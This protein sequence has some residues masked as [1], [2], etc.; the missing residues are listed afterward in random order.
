MIPDTHNTAREHIAGIGVD[1][2][3]ID[4]IRR[5]LQTYGRSFVNRVF[6]EPEQRYCGD[7][8][9]PAQHYAARFA[10]KEAAMKV[11]G[12]GWGNGIGW[13]D[14]SV[15]RSP[16]APPELHISGQAQDVAEALGITN[17]HL[18]LSHGS[19]QALAFCLGEK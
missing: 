5:S 2:V 1:I 18:S 8:A 10:A 13:P 14:I 9:K 15:H 16:D 11:L 7:K 3:S 12:T 17:F 4:R 19:D 6:T